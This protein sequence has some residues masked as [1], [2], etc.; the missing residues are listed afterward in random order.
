MLCTFCGTENRPENKFCGMCGV[1]LERRKA[2]RRAR[3]DGLKCQACG[4]SNDSGQKFCGMCG[5]RVD[6]RAV[7]R[8]TPSPAEP[9]ATAM[10]NAQLP[11][12]ETPG[13]AA[14]LAPMVAVADQPK[15]T[16]PSPVSEVLPHPKAQPAIFRNEPP[17][18]TGVSGPSF[19]GLG[20]EPE[21]PGEYLLEDEGSSGGMLRRLVLIAILAA[22]AG[23]VFVGWRSS[24]RASPKSPPPPQPQPTESASPQSKGADSAPDTAQSA[25]SSDSSPANDAPGDAKDAPDDGKAAA[26]A[27]AVTG[28]ADKISSGK[29]ESAAPRR[30]T[31]HES[32]EE[33]S[34]GQRRPSAMLLLA[35]Q[36]LQGRGGVKQNCEQ[37][38]TYLKA[39]TQKNEPAAAVQMGALYASGHCV[40]RDQVSAY[41]WFN[42]AHEL[43]PANPWIQTNLDQLW[44]EMT[45]QQRHQ[46]GQ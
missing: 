13:R 21:N 46:V 34:P 45:P 29:D 42:S 25:K 7:E 15:E 36:Y 24:S 39:A 11:P 19:L 3:Q 35:Q 23:L 10:A 27:P 28:G 9:R 2:E 8:R 40:Q 30:K 31:S 32:P 4:H 16:Q 37:G 41:R 38:L 6:R 33:P 26:A 20:D 44:A 43:D 5:S 22:I 17:R 1:R 14:E 12:P 18:A